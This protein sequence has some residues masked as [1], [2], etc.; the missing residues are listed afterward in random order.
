MEL[1]QDIPSGWKGCDLEN[2]R[3]KL[4]GDLVVQ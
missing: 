3:E 2:P 4:Q 1:P